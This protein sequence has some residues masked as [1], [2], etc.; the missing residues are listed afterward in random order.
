MTEKNS[1]RGKK[2]KATGADFERRVRKD[3]ELKGW[4]VAKWPNNVSD[5]P[6]D[7]IN[8]PLGLREDRKLI[9]AK[10]KFNPFSKAMMLGGGFPDFIAYKLFGN[11]VCAELVNGKLERL[12]GTYGVI[13]VES[14]VQGY[15]DKV[16][17]LKCEWLLKNKIFS[18]ILIASKTKVKNK[19]VIVYKEF[20]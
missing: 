11:G 7:N 17:K 13:G 8:R 2:A 12:D 15:L 20:K 19:V 5:F 14:K 4:I 1:K 10:N 16:E 3:I 9:P 6:A 18:K